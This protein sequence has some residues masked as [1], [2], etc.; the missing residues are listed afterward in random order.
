ML[1]Q[2]RLD[3]VG[4]DEQLG[5]DLAVGERRRQVAQ[6]RP[7]A[8][9]QRLQQRATWRAL[10]LAVGERVQQLADDRAV[11]GARRGSGGAAASSMRRPSSRNAQRWPFASA[12]ASARSS[13]CAGAVPGSPA[14]RGR[15]PRARRARHGPTR[16]CRLGG[17]GALERSR[18]RPPGRRA[19]AQ[20]R[21]GDARPPATARPRTGASVASAAVEVP[22]A[23]CRRARIAA[24]EARSYGA[25][26]RRGGGAGPRS[27]RARAAPRA[28][29]GRG[30]PCAPRG[31]RA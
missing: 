8:L 2:V 21:R 1:A 25:A 15:A 29:A 6:D 20:P 23:A 24:S 4:G 27:R 11:R 7:L 10:V 19:R 26:R 17:R 22:A 18:P 31:G 28:A 12:S 3:R 5:G 16:A 30:P 13:A 14:C 9:G